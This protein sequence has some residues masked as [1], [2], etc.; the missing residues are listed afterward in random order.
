MHLGGAVARQRVDGPVAGGQ[1]E[2]RAIALTYSWTSAPCVIIA[3]LGRAVVP[4][5]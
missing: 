5:V 1:A 3:P 4:E 2:G